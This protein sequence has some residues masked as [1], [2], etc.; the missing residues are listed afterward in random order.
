MNI[1]MSGSGSGGHIYP[2][3]SL[4]KELIKENK[5]TLVIF[6]AIDKKIYELNNIKYTYIDDNLSPLKKIKEIRNIFKNNNVDM[7]MTFGGKNSFFIQLVSKTLKVKSFIFEQNA[8]I[9]K[10][11]KVNL[12]F[13]DKMF[14]NFKINH[15]KAIKIGNPNAYNIKVN[16]INLFNNNKITL[17]ITMGSLGSSSVNK[18]IE[19]FIKNNKEYNIIYVTGNNVKTSLKNNEYLK[20]YDFYNPLTDLINI[21][22]IVITRAGASTLS[23]IIYFNKPMIIIPSPYVANNHQEKNANLLLKEKACQV[24]FEKDLNINILTSKI[25]NYSYNEDFYNKTIDN[26]KKC[27][28]NVGFKEL[29]D[30]LQL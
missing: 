9:G 28:C 22:H 24:I 21:S 19:N 26:I 3:I 30:Y 10:A 5:I 6:K 20:I 15:K 7:T 1:L 12:L 4:Y 29:K 8:I 2:C 11:N 14:T 23:E 27:N 18:V 25:R 16:K 17:L 13:A